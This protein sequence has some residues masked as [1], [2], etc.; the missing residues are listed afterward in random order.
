MYFGCVVSLTKLRWMFILFFSSI[1][2]FCLIQTFGLMLFID[3]WFSKWYGHHL[4][5][6]SWNHFPKKYYYFLSESLFSSN[7]QLAVRRQFIILSDR[8][9]KKVTECVCWRSIVKGEK[10]RF[11]SVFFSSGNVLTTDHWPYNPWTSL[12]R[13]TQ[14]TVWQNLLLKFIQ[15]F[16]NKWIYHRSRSFIA[17]LQSF[18]FRTKCHHS[19]FNFFSIKH[20]S[21]SICKSFIFELLPIDPLISI[22][23]NSSLNFGPNWYID[24]NN[25]PIK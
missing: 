7:W 20:F 10:E 2:S 14:L 23:C 6:L 5:H 12:R 3:K 4:S 1:F 13:S 8:A 15:L 25:F 9:S 21:H 19:P 16:V 24:F 22:E 17:W 11:P 18:P